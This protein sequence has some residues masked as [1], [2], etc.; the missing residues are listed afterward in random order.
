MGTRCATCRTKY[1]VARGHGYGG[2]LRLVAHSAQ[3]KDAGGE[4]KSFHERVFAVLKVPLRIPPRTTSNLIGF[5]Q[6]Q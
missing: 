6:S 1:A 3:R 2:D 4:Q 5:V